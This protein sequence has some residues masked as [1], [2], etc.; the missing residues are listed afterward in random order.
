MARL[1]AEM[2]FGTLLKGIIRGMLLQ[3]LCPTL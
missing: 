1:P 3:L 2:P